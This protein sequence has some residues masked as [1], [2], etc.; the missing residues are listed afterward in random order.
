[1]IIMPP[2]RFE[3]NPEEDVTSS[4]KKSGAINAPVKDR[5]SRKQ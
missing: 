2:D 3:K 5:A 4:K 1:M